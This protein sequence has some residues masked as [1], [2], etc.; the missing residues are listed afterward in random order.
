M[1]SRSITVLYG[2]AESPWIDPWR[3]VD[4][5][6]FVRPP[7]V[8]PRVPEVDPDAL[9]KALALLNGTPCAVCGFP[10]VEEGDSHHR[11][12]SA[13]ERAER[14]GA[15]E[16]QEA[17]GARIVALDVL[18]QPEGVHPDDCEVE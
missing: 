14:R 7:I 1:S 11:C 10:N 4:P 9:E 17:S 12:R 2:V 16:A 6:D 8:W 15:K 18:I 5:N 13:I 3:P